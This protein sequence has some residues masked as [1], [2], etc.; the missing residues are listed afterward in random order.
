MINSINLCS[1]TCV[2]MDGCDFS[3]EDDICERGVSRPAH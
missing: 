3:K 1:F 2:D